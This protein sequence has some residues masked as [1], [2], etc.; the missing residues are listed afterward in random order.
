MSTHYD[1]RES[2]LVEYIRQ[3]ELEKTELLNAIKR[4]YPCLDWANFKD[5]KDL[6]TELLWRYKIKNITNGTIKK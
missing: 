3:L 2:E 6:L 1:N 5:E 4:I